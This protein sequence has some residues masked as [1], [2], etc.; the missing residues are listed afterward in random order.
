MGVVQAPEVDLLIGESPDEGID[1]DPVVDRGLSRLGEGGMARSR[2][3]VPVVMRTAGVQIGGGPEIRIRIKVMKFIG[4]VTGIAGDLT[5]IAPT[6]EVHEKGDIA[7]RDIE[8]SSAMRTKV[9]VLIGT[10][11]VQ[12]ETVVAPPARGCPLTIAVA[13]PTNDVRPDQD[14]G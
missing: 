5:R 13:H 7:P 8:R 10:H 2:V 12:D 14:P 11:L 9:A 3:F 4:I 6:R 1:A